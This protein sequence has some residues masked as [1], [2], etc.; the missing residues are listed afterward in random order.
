[1]RRNIHTNRLDLLAHAFYNGELALNI[2]TFILPNEWNGCKG[3]AA[4]LYVDFFSSFIATHVTDTFTKSDPSTLKTYI[5]ES[6]IFGINAKAAFTTPAFNIEAA[7]KIFEIHPW[8]STVNPNLNVQTASESDVYL[9]Q[10]TNKTFI[11]QSNPPYFQFDIMVQYNTGTLPAVSAN[12]SKTASNS[13]VFLKF[14]HITNF[15]NPTGNH[16]SNSYFQLQLGYALDI[17]KLLNPQ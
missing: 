1:M 13:N 7:A 11:R 4:H 10:N 14:S 17:T 3:D 9:K 15:A 6:S 8:S 5:V 12:Q 16:Y 2:V